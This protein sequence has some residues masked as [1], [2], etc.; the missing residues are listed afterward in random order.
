MYPWNNDKKLDTLQIESKG[1]ILTF[2]TQIDLARVYFNDSGIEK[3]ECKS[4]EVQETITRPHNI[5]VGQGNTHREVF[6]YLK[7]NGPAKQ[8]RL[9]ITKH[10]GLGTWSS[11]P[12]EFEKNTEPDFEEVFFYLLSGETKRAIQVG[13]GV[14]FDGESV[15]SVWSVR[16]RSFCTIPMGYHPVV[17]EP[18]VQVCYIWAYLAKKNEWEKL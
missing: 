13:R 15:D 8:L 11:L 6:H 1:S 14:W 7:P 3:V 12:H 18:G 9:G 5:S 2:E 4:G 16:D 17:A 10:S